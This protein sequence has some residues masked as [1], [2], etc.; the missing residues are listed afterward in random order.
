MKKQKLE[1]AVYVGWVQFECGWGITPDGCSLHLTE[2]DAKAF[3][4]EYWSS[5]LPDGARIVRV[6]Q[7]LYEEIKKTKNGVRYS[8]S[9]EIK[10]RGSGDLIVPIIK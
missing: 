9:Y 1:D 8:Y 4:K 10:L 6:S 7:N 5:M 2:A 3:E